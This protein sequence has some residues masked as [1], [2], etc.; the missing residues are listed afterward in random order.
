MSVP[1]TR[2][3]RADCPDCGARIQLQSPVQ[4]GQEVTCPECA[5]ELEVIQTNPVELDWIYEDDEGEEDED[6]DW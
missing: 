1:K 5:A 3:V 6:E 2:T 4:L